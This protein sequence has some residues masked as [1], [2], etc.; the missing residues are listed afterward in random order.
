MAEVKSP[1]NSVCKVDPASGV[2]IGCFRTLEEISAWSA[3]TEA[4]RRAIVDRAEARLGGAPEL[5]ECSH[6]RTLFSC[7][8]AGECWCKSL[9]PLKPV[10][11]GD[12]LCPM[13]LRAAARK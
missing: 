13:C 7:G 1:C 9:P 8:I 10:E 4:Q 2:C 3:S 6:C 12:C 5:K 11:G